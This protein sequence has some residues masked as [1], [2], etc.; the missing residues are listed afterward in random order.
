MISGLGIILGFCLLTI[1]V[2]KRLNL[3]IIAILSAAIITVFSG[4]PLMSTLSGPFIQ[5]FSSFAAPFLLLFVAGALFG[6]LMDDSGATWRIGTSIVS[7]AGERWALAAYIAVASLLL[8]G[9]VSVFV[10]V[11]VLLPVA[12]SIFKMGNIPWYLFPL[13]TCYSLLFPLYMLPGGLQVANIIP[14]K[15]LGTDLM[16]GPLEGLF[17]TVIFVGFGAFYIAYELKKGKSRLGLPESIPPA[18]A[19]ETDYEK[20]DKTAPGVWL[21]LVPIILALVSINIFKVDVVL[22]LTFA[23]LACILLF[24]KS[25]DRLLDTINQGAT[26]GIMP[27]IL[28]AIV[29]G[30]AKVVAITP[31]FA[32]FKDWLI[33]LNISGLL[34]ILVVTNAI[35]AITGSATGSMTM[36]LEMFGKDFLAMG[37]NPETIHRLIAVSASALDTLPWNSFIVLL[38]TLSG[39]TYSNGYKQVFIISVILPLLAALG[40]AI[41]F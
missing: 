15:Y 17:A 1:G 12:R 37:Y 9:G 25:F 11:F 30:V 40:I 14:T 3:I 13:I 8:Y 5:G 41:I 16:A 38:F 18:V 23:S 29:V 2:W 27:L 28:V 32:L 26:N 22:G 24:Y 21:S 34:K 20:L 39:V 36:T 7:K 33:A 4:Q 35:S 10:V 31:A 6:K 19:K